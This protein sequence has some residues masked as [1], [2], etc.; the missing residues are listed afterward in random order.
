MAVFTGLW[1]RRVPLK[2][3]FAPHPIS[4]LHQWLAF[5]T[6][7]C[8]YVHYGFH[9]YCWNFFTSFVFQQWLYYLWICQRDLNLTSL[10]SA[11]LF[12]LFFVPSHFFFVGSVPSGLTFTTL[13]TIQLLH[14]GVIIY[15][16]EYR[17]LIVFLYTTQ[18]VFFN[19]FFSNHL[20]AFL[21]RSFNQSFIGFPAIQLFLQ[22]KQQLASKC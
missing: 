9:Q 10:N 12:A 5:C 19:Y 15:A 1:V 13:A 20:S 16:R 21:A 8:I 17:A 18:S 14:S 22:L 11:F 3:L 7:D 2:G 6:S 4:Y